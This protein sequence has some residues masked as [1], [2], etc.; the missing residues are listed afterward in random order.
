MTQNRTSIAILLIGGLLLVL[1]PYLQGGGTDENPPQPPTPQPVPGERFVLIVEESADR[2]AA[3]AT[4]LFS[5]RRYLNS[6]GLT[7]QVTD[8]D[9]TEAGQPSPWLQPYL[10]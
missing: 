8:Q 7:Y 5:L 6:N 3:N 2:S 10:E 1:G 4:T 9:Q